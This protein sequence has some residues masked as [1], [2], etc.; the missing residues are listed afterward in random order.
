[1]KRLLLLISVFCS[2]SIFT[3]GNC[4]PQAS[5]SELR[6]QFINPNFGGNPFNGQ[7][8]L[9]SAVLQND[10]A[11]SQNQGND[12]GQLE[13]FQNRLD[14]AVL[15]RLS[16]EIVAEAFGEDSDLSAGDI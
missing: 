2:M 1:M 12:T 16:R 14:R 4:I 11:D 5:A 7:P 8:L 13:D 15:N 10:F 6:H 9:N 3:W